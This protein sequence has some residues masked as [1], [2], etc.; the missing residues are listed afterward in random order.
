MK[1]NINIKI[2][3]F[4]LGIFLT[5]SLIPTIN[6]N[7]IMGICSMKSEDSDGIAFDNKNLRP[8]EFS[9]KVH[10][11][12]NW[13][14]AW[15]AGICTGNGTYSNPYVI[16]DLVIDGGGSGSCI[17]IENSNVYF[18]IENCTVYNS[19]MPA[20]PPFDFAGI[21]LYNITTGQ[22]IGNN[23]SIS[24]Y[25]GIY[26]TDSDNNSISGNTANDNVYG[27]RLE[28]SDN[29]IISGNTAN[30]NSNGICVIEGINNII[31]ENKANDNSDGI[32]LIMC[33]SSDISRNNANDNYEGIYID[34]C[35]YNTISE[36]IFNNSGDNGMYLSS[37][38]YNNISGNTVNHNSG[39]GIYSTSSSNNND[40]LGNIVNNNYWG[41]N[42]RYSDN[43]DILGNTVNMNENY[44]IF[45]WTS[46]Y[47][48]VSG[49]ELLGN[50]ECIKEVNCKGNEFS[51]NDG[52]K[53]G[54]GDKELI[55]PGYNLFFLLGI[56]SG[57]AFILN[58]K[59]KKY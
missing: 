26:L 3:I 13:T 37:S 35:D 5:L 44:G 20:F 15:D 55:I 19:E 46:N 48:T 58:R 11:D 22:L 51:D 10:I 9:G 25:Y 4:I 45:L 53:Y 32:K 2:S 47:T 28:Y 31:S 18:R 27:I 41:M 54:E 1:R 8:S 24:N 42:I 17:L 16:E 49:N 23:C 12:N 57:V 36:N 40:I 56:L 34:R 14:D 29:N 33:H 7:F 59:I 6:F 52:C 30:S 38:N 43:N 39:A 21:K 50:L